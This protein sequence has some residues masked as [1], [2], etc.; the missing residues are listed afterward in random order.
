MKES[1]SE[2]ENI[3]H[4]VIGQIAKGNED[5]FDKLFA[6]F[7]EPLCRFAFSLLK[8]FDKSQSLVQNV[9]VKIWDKRQALSTVKNISSYLFSLT[10]NECIDYLRTNKR[11]TPLDDDFTDTSGE[12]TTEHALRLN[13]L[14]EQILRGTTYLPARCRQVFELSRF[15]AL[16]N[17]EIADEMGITVKAVEANLTRALKFLRSFLGDYMTD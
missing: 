15:E 6:H 3:W 9:F 5:A 10:R 12:D 14:N 1:S 13:E 17:R 4:F 2:R 7:Y 8:D 16:N 11:I